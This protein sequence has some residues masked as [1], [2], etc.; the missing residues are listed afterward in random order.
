[1]TILVGTSG[2]S[3]PEWKGSFYPEKL[4]QKKM[5]SYYAEHFCTVEINATFYRMPK[6]DMLAGWIAE[7]PPD[8]GFVLKAPQRITHH[9]K[10]EDVGEETARFTTVAKTMGARLGPLLYQLPPFLKKDLPRLEAFLASVPRPSPIVI[11][12]G[13]ASWFSDDVYELLKAQDAAMCIVD[14]PSPRKAAPFE[15]TAKHGY[16]RLRRVEYGDA[17]VTAWAKRIR[18]AKWDT[19]HVFF[20]HED[21]GTGPALAKRMLAALGQTR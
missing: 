19:A 15:K 18:D 5:L 4:P 21:E 16:L 8:F 9:K 11:E 1:M 20:K 13:D 14:D 7:V 2:F 3:Y 10:L 6:E 12:M 17:E